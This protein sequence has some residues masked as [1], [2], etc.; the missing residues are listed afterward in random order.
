MSFILRG[1]QQEA[2]DIGIDFFK[3]VDRTRP[4]L[5]LPTAAGKSIVIAKIAHALPNRKILIMQPS[6][7]LLEQNYKKYEHVIAEHPELEPASIYS[8]SVGVKEVGRITFAM[9]GSIYKKPELFADV[10]YVIIDECHFVPPARTSMYMQFFSRL[11]AV[12]V[13][14]LTATPYRLKTYVDP[15]NGKKF[16]KINLLNRER[17]NFFNKFLYIV[18]AKRL[19]DEGFLCPVNYIEMQFDGSFLQVN[20][21]G[22][23][24]TEQSLKEAIERNQILK[25]IPGVL[26]QAFKKGRKACLV[27]VRAVDEARQLAAITPFSGYLHALT[28]K[29]ERAETVRNFKNGNIKTIFNV[30]ILTTGFDYPELDTVILAR[31]TMSL[32]LYVQMIGRGVR[33]APGKDHLS[34]LDMCGN[35]KRF[36][37]I[38]ELRVELDPNEGWVLR[39]DRQILSGRRLDELV[40]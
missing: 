40:K 10:D 4:M 18:H 11:P 15:F 7:E 23:E 26:D 21:T 39:N 31:P 3:S 13:L 25:K 38:E 16:S 12:K 2:T 19:Y 5:V 22:A 36:G 14:G 34:M 6:K 29:K 27:F 1:Y 32:T 30:G 28:P 35:L 37:K 20:S 17:P 9:I 33:L 8:A 24:Y